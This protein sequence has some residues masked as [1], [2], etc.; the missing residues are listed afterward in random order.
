MPRSAPNTHV[1]GLAGP[2]WQNLYQARTYFC[3]S[4]CKHRAKQASVHEAFARQTMPST[5]A[6]QWVPRA[7]CTIVAV[8]DCKPTWNPSYQEL[9]HIVWV[10]R[11][12][13]AACIMHNLRPTITVEHSS[14]CQHS[15]RTWL[16]C[17][18]GQSWMQ[19]VKPR[20]QEMQPAGTQRSGAG[21]CLQQ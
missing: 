15:P 12:G 17:L 5:A 20:M 4:A 9:V 7:R 1:T 6:E 14:L 13:T 18:P 16:H 3:M 21:R 2:F 8:N 19:R 10:L 11:L